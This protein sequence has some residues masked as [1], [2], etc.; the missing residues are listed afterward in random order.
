MLCLVLSGQCW[1][2]CCSLE[3]T[4]RD[5]CSSMVLTSDHCCML[6]LSWKP[7]P[8]TAPFDCQVWPANADI[9]LMSKCVPW[10]MHSWEHSSEA[11]QD[12]CKDPLAFQQVEVMSA[13]AHCS[14]TARASSSA[15]VEGRDTH[16]QPLSGSDRSLL[17]HGVC[18]S[19][20]T[21]VPPSAALAAMELLC[22]LSLGVFYSS[23]AL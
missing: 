22:Y 10:D 11:G 16:P 13:T 3:N 9:I 4:H 20:Q 2:S 15:L 21:R 23:P 12:S 5:G 19:F 7:K 18:L 8:R 6:C 1:L 17:G 14:L